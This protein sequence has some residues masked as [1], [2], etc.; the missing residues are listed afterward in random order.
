VIRPPA[1]YP[2]SVNALTPRVRVKN[3]HTERRFAAAQRNVKSLE[4]CILAELEEVRLLALSL[5]QPAAAVAASMGT[6]KDFWEHCSTS[7]AW[8]AWRL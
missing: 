7:R 1:E 5:D 8:Q 4:S 2:S 3:W 6:A